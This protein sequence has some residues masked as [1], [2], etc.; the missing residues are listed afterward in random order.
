MWR[1]MSWDG[2]QAEAGKPLP[3]IDGLP[4][5]QVQVQKAEGRAAAD[6]GGAAAL[7]GTGHPDHRRARRSD[8]SQL[9]ARR[10]PSDV[11]SAQLRGDTVRGGD[12]DQ[13]RSRDGDAAGRPDARDHRRTAVRQPAG[14]DPADER[15]DEE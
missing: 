9:L 11:D 1:T 7:L 2:A 10:R 13:R 6:G 14:D 15:G 12:A 4:V 5:V 8:V 3:H